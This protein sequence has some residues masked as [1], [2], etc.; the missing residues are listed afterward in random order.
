MYWLVLVSPF[1]DSEHVRFLCS[2]RKG[3][4]VCGFDV[5]QGGRDRKQQPG[6]G[7]ERRRRGPGG[8]DVRKPAAFVL[9]LQMNAL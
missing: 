4:R 9:F 2:G 8:P 7:G 6:G 5:L 3:Q 1:S